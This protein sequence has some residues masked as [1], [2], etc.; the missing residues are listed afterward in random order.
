MLFMDEQFLK[1]VAVILL[2]IS[3]AGEMVGMYIFTSL[4]VP[5]P[6][7]EQVPFPDEVNTSP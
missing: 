7:T 5:I 3:P 6:L 4:Q 2:T 1:A